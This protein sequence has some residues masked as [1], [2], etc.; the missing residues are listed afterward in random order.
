MRY[1][2]L[3]HNGEP[4]PGEIPAE[5]IAEMERLFA[6][7]GQ[8]LESA[9]VLVAGEVLQFSD[10]ATTV[11]R[12]TGATQVQDGP[13]AETKEA[14]AGIFV[15]EVPDADAAIAWAEKCPGASYGS[16]EVRPVATS[17]A[18]GV[19]TGHGPAE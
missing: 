12:R 1:A 10:T 13:F 15:V 11:T 19:W 6:E 8:A 2:L 5:G 14:L 7:Y 3:L 16:V 18:G 4:A 17:L 9:G